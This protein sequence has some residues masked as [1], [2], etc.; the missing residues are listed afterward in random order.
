MQKQIILE[1]LIKAVLKQIDPRRQT[2]S[3]CDI[4]FRNL[5]ISNLLSPSLLGFFFTQIREIWV[6][7]ENV[8]I[9]NSLSWS[10]EKKIHKNWFCLVVGGFCLPLSTK[11]LNISLFYRN[12][13]KFWVWVVEKTF[14]NPSQS[15]AFLLGDTNWKSLCQYLWV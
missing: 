9:E 1:N 6:S 4:I 15:L 14:H 13:R 11:N 8:S 12:S 5:L 10:S 2:F 3:F 7:E